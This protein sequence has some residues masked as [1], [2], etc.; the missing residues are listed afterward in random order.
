[1]LYVYPYVYDCRYFDGSYAPGGRFF[2]S[3]GTDKIFHGSAAI[4]P[5]TLILVSMLSTRYMLQCLYMHAIR[6][7]YRVV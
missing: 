7:V 3:V 1:M 2:A 6:T 5:T 4:N